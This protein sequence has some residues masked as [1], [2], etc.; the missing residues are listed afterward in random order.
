LVRVAAVATGVAGNAMP[1]RM[2]T[3]FMVPRVMRARSKTDTTRNT[4]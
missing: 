2:L 1:T 4:E 3:M